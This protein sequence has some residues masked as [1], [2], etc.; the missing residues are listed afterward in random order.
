[1]SQTKTTTAAHAATPHLNLDLDLAVADLKAIRQ[2]WS[3]I[4]GR[5][6][7]NHVALPVPETIIAAID[8]L[9]LALFPQRLGRIN[10]ST[11]NEDHFVRKHLLTAS[12]DLQ[13]QIGLELHHR[14]TLN[15]GLIDFT[16]TQQH[17]AH[18][19]SQL[20]QALPQIRS[21]LEEDLLAALRGDPAAK[22]TDEII[23][24]Y[25]GW[26]AIVHYRLA[27][28]FY[29]QNLPIVSRII[30]EHAHSKT[31]IDIHPGAQI[32]SGLFIDHGTGVVIGETAIIGN[33]VRIYQ[34]VTLGAKRF[35]EGENGYLHKGQAR[36]PI[37]ED[38]VVIYAGATILGRITIGK[39]SVI[40]GN[41]WLTHSTP[42]GS[43]I[44]QAI[45][46]NASP[47]EVFINGAGI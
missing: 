7:F 17:I 39:A 27:H 1:M 5:G 46:R 11:V 9:K 12:L 35:T 28:F 14:A 3:S 30:A 13:Q 45:T 10:P 26:N 33:N 22:S 6:E 19:L 34:A 16:E 4:Q 47:D 29:Q 38:E 37:I 20:L 18:I 21:T 32:G 44:S 42:P 25:P 15:G 23:L 8:N 2:Q 24:S 36:H 41:V 43:Q 40:G 31:G